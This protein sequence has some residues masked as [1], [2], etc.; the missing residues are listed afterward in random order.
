MTRILMAV[1]A[2]A[3]AA[4]TLPAADH[5]TKS[6]CAKKP[7]SK[8]QATKAEKLRCG[9]TGKVVD[10]CCCVERQGKTHCT[11]ADKDVTTCCCKAMEDQA[12]TEAR[13]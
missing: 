8:E 6:C 10:R 3:F 1:S 9:L 5:A 12:T 7:A 11:L 2:A 4:A 13:K